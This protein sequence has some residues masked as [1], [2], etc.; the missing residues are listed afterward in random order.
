[1]NHLDPS[2]VDGTVA[3][4]GVDATAPLH[5]DVERVRIPEEILAE[6]KEF[7]DRAVGRG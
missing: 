7:L 2:S 3:K 4:M 1:M 6:A 5:W